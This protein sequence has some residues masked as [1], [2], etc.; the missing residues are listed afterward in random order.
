[1]KTIMSGNNMREMLRDS[2]GIIIR[3]Y[4]ARHPEEYSAGIGSYYFFLG[5]NRKLHER[6]IERYLAKDL[7]RNPERNCDKNPRRNTERVSVIPRNHKENSGRAYEKISG[8][9]LGTI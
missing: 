4:S 5:N 6:L 8:R 1:M 9:H 3:R 2:A 7:R